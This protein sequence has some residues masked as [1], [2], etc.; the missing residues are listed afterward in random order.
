MGRPFRTA[1]ASLV[2]LAVALLAAGGCAWAEQPGVPAA[3]DQLVGTLEEGRTY[4][5]VDGHSF[6]GKDLADFLVER[7]WEKEL[8]AFVERVLVQE[9]MDRAGVAVGEQEVDAELA[10]LTREYARK[11]GLAP[12]QFTAAEMVRRVRTSLEFLRDQTRTLLGLRQVLIK[13][14]RLK[15][16][17]PVDGPAARQVLNERLESRIK[18]R[19]VVTDPEKLAAGEAARIGTRSFP[20]GAVR[21][22]ILERLGPLLRSEIKSVLDTLT[23]A[24]LMQRAL[25]NAGRP[26]IEYE[27]RA[28]HFSYLARMLEAEQNAPNG[29]EALLMQLKQ[30]GLSV[31]QF[32][33][34]PAFT[35][36]SGITCLAR[37]VIKERDLR[38]EYDANPGDYQRT[39]KRLAHLFIRVR[40]RQGRPYRAQWEVEGHQKVNEAVSAEREDRF[41]EARPKI[42]RLVG[43]A[44][45]N[46]AEAAARFSEDTTTRDSGGLIGRV[47][48][49]TAMPEPLDRDLLRQALKL[50]P[51]E[52][53]APLPSAYGWHLVK[54]LEEQQT[55]YEEAR[56]HVYLRL[57]KRK[58]EEIFRKLL[59]EAKIEDAF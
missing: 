10:R 25:R 57:L 26:A 47:G 52:V 56:E 6:T 20:R 32:I 43:L 39:E 14:G 16:S 31:E 33:R 15:P 23:Y 21:G 55:T 59:A 1:Q 9:E 44:R 18:A 48:P 30:Q 35:L 49:N 50:K 41:A 11:E 53:S 37:H 22:F 46:F 54:C 27:D 42:E 51:G 12:N 34:E 7:D 36:D 29:R 2:A 4:R 13:E 3:D 28:F 24:F 17:D 19:G 45:G 5:R 40:D 58:R 8:P 38:A